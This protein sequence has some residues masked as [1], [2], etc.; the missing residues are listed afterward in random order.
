MKLNSKQRAFLRSEAQTMN[1]VVNVG[2]EGLTDGVVEHLNAA[3]ESH[4]LVKVRFQNSK[5]QVMEISRA[6]EEK[7]GSVI[8]A[9][10][11][12]TTVFFRQ[13]EKDPERIYII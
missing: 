9:T 5:D 11:G 1:P 12:F 7:T 10:T 6:L 2:K 3:L 13:D 8:V 4:E